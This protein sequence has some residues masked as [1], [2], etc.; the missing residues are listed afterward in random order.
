MK[1][2]SKSQRMISVIEQGHV[3]LY[4]TKQKHKK[5]LINPRMAQQETEDCLNWR[6]SEIWMHTLKNIFW[7]QPQHGGST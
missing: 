4:K 3:Q 1:Q 2:L 6:S 7:E 5:K